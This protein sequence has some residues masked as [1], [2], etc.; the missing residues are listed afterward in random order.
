MHL[1]DRGQAVAG[2]GAARTANPD[3]DPAVKRCKSRF[4]HAIVAYVNRHG[5]DAGRG[6]FGGNGQ[7][8][9]A[10]FARRQ[11][12]DFFAANELQLT[13][14]RF[15]NTLHKFT[16]LTNSVFGDAPVVNGEGQ[17]LCLRAILREHSAVS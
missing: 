12:P 10:N 2:V 9:V 17:A 1:L 7:A 3:G 4:V 8:F 13:G 6:Q 15:E 16:G 5:V 14:K 11:L